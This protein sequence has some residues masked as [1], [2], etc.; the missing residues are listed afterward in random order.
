MAFHWPSPIPVR[1]DKSTKPS[2]CPE[3]YQYPVGLEKSDNLYGLQQLSVRC[4]TC[5]LIIFASSADDIQQEMR[6]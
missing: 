1:R 4:N 2:T 3:V 5:S 6:Q